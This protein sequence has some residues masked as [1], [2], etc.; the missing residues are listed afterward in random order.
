MAKGKREVTLTAE[1]KMEIQHELDAMDRIVANLYADSGPPTFGHSEF[2]VFPALMAGFVALARTAYVQGRDYVGEQNLVEV[3]PEQAEY[4]AEKFGRLFGGFVL[5]QA[6]AVRVA[7][8]NGLGVR[9]AERVLAIVDRY[10]HD[11][12]GVDDEMADTMMQ[13][14]RAELAGPSGGG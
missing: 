5:W 9:E 4:I 1:R 12:A 3:D 13:G 10:V 7:F 8:L 14:I 11:C 2:R 6:R